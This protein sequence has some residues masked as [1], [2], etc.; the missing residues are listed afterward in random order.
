M[1]SNYE[2][3]LSLEEFARLSGRSLSGFKNEFKSIFDENSYEVDFEK[4]ST[5]R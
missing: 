3:D 4:K 1:E 2:K 5:E